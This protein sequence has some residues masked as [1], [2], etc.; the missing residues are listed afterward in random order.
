VVAVE[1]LSL[2]SAQALFFQLL[3]GAI[4]LSVAQA[5]FANT[6]IKVRH[7]QAQNKPQ[8]QAFIF[9]SSAQKKADFFSFPA[10]TNRVYQ[11]TPISTQR[12]S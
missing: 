4:W 8:P 6:L 1:D 2:A 10:T 3:G 7:T 9:F 11:A 5:L 12:V